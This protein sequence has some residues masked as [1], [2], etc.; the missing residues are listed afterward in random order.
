MLEKELLYKSQRFEDVVTLHFLESSDITY[1][2][3]RPKPKPQTATQALLAC[4][5]PGRGVQGDLFYWRAT[6]GGIERLR[7]AGAAA[8]QRVR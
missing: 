4:E 6:V 7:I 2:A 5:N 3:V 8:D 1:N